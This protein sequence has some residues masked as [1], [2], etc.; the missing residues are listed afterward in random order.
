MDPNDHAVTREFAWLWVWATLGLSAAVGA[1]VTF[2]LWGTNRSEHRDAF[3]TGWKSSAAVLAVLAAVVTVERLRLGQREHL[4]QLASDRAKE[5]TDLSSKA[6]EQLGSEK[7]AVR[8]G[9][10]TD[11]ERLAQSYPQLRQTVVDRICAYLRAP[12]ALPPKRTRNGDGRSDASAGEKTNLEEEMIAARRLELDVRRTAQQI[13]RRHL[14]IK[15]SGSQSDA[16][17]GLVNLDLRDATLFEFDM[18][19]CKVGDGDFRNASFVGRT[20][21][22]STDFQGIARFDE[23]SFDDVAHFNEAVFRSAT[24]FELSRFESFATFEKVRFGGRTEIQ[25]VHFGTAVSFNGAKF[26]ALADFFGTEFKDGVRMRNITFSEVSFAE[27]KTGRGISFESVHFKGK[28]DFHRVAF[29]ERPKYMK[30]RFEQLAS[31][32]G[33]EFKKGGL[34][35]QCEFVRDVNFAESS[36]SVKFTLDNVYIA[37]GTSGRVL[38]GTWKV[39]NQVAPA[40]FLSNGSGFGNVSR[41]YAFVPLSTV[42]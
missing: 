31:F 33:S 29:G 41:A 4:R 27:I 5:I 20:S 12:Y 26:E 9:G 34:F 28:V 14:L 6:S 32:K 30:V 16:Y 23:A 18:E 42:E 10:L 11:L 38:P 40:R 22:R 19:G 1:L 8:M 25:N 15:P 39:E 36:A 21:F 35:T 3:D 24:W 17:W 13:L 2:L 7:A 37:L